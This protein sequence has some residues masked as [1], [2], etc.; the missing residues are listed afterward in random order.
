M[1]LDG[2]VV[3]RMEGGL[4]V[5]VRRAV[6]SRRGIDD[7]VARGFLS[8]LVPGAF[9][10]LASAMPLIVNEGFCGIDRWI[11]FDGRGR[12]EDYGMAAPD[13]TLLARE[14]G[15]WPQWLYPGDRQGAQFRKYGAKE[16]LDA[17]WGGV[18]ADAACR[19]GAAAGFYVE[20][21]ADWAFARSSAQMIAQLLSALSAN[22]ELAMEASG[23][24]LLEKGPQGRS[25]VAPFMLNPESV[26]DISATISPASLQ[27]L[28][29][30]ATEEF[31]CVGDWSCRALSFPDRSGCGPVLVATPKG[32]APKVRF[33]SV[34]VGDRGQG[35][36]AVAAV[37]AIAET[38]AFLGGENAFR[39]NGWWFEGREA[40]EDSS[41]GLIRGM[42]TASELVRRVV[43]RGGDRLSTCKYCHT[44][45]LYRARGAEKMY[46]TPRCRMA[47][48]Q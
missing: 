15:L 39:T 17:E 11:P 35:E 29:Y 24:E 48:K 31:D 5:L 16:R 34:A 25:W 14:V 44:P 41:V 6:G 18:V 32:G 30:A 37:E 22:R 26:G 43:F 10:D 3:A 23:F 4:H 42:S 46:C 21:L 36:D 40:L 27:P 19:M 7:G 13:P 9:F 38:F 2:Y 47:D 33:I 12:L 45:L 28:F 20:P 1:L 8:R